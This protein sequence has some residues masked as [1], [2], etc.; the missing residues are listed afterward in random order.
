MAA[1]FKGTFHSYC[2]HEACRLNSGVRPR[3]AGNKLLCQQL[4]LSQQFTLVIGAA[5]SRRATGTLCSFA[6]CLSQLRLFRNRFLLTVTL[7]RSSHCSP[8]L[9]HAVFRAGLIRSVAALR[10]KTGRL[11]G[12]PAI[13]Y[14]LNRQ[15]KLGE[16]GLTIHSSRNRFVAPQLSCGFSGG[17]GLIQALGPA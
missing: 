16:R 2:G 14:L 10:L 1:K 3:T 9:L 4:A 12:S 7:A 15:A 13:G 17:F 6:L 8:F 5:S 11:A